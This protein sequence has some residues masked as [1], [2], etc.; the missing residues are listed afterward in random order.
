MRILLRDRPNQ[1]QDIPAEFCR[2]ISNYD[3]ENNGTLNFEEFYRMCQ[4]HEW[5]VR[6]WGV[7]YCKFLVAPRDPPKHKRPIAAA[8]AADY[9]G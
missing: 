4:D 3:V 8:A 1:C 5:L 9:T 6:D 7:K 2:Q